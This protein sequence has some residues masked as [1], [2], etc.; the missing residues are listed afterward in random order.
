MLGDCKH[1]GAL[2]E[3]CWRLAKRTGLYCCAKCQHV[4]VALPSAV[5]TAS[6]VPDKEFLHVQITASGDV[7]MFTD[8]GHWEHS[9]IE[10]CDQQWR[11]ATRV[12]FPQMDKEC[13]VGSIS[14]EQDVTFRIPLKRG[15][16]RLGKFGM[17][18]I[19]E[20]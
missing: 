17:P 2:D 3:P 16:K 9:P 6:A 20:L 11:E 19:E 15:R 13:F 12:T 7:Y 1:C 14:S 4:V 8:N 10:S 18:Y 5:S